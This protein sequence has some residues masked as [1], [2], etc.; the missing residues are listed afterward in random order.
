MSQLEVK[1]LKIVSSDGLTNDT[2]IKGDILKSSG[3]SISGSLISSK[4][5]ILTTSGSRFNIN[6]T[7]VGNFHIVE[8][9]QGESPTSCK[10]HGTTFATT[11]G[12]TQAGIVFSEN[13]TDGTAVGIYTTDSYAGGPRLGVSVDP[14][15]RVSTPRQ[16]YI[17]GSPTNTSNSG[18]ANSFF[19]RSSRNLS[20]AN[21]RI[22]VPIAGVYLI[23]FNTISTE[24]SSRV[25]SNIYIN[26]V[27]ALSALSENS[28]AGFHM[29]SLSTAIMLAAGDF[30]Q[31]NNN[32]WYNWSVT[33]W[34]AWRTASVVLLG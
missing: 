15:G 4:P 29:K 1:S 10:I 26:G 22:T 3:G 6:K 12:E 18:L 34:D 25:D 30:I 9:V 14:L 28:A 32:N 11:P 27:V 23:T 21:N 13:S 16:P 2:F 24:T 8:P 20:W 7:S 17:F 5:E 31:F 19:T 33:E